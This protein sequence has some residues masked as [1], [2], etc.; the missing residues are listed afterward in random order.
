MGNIPTKIV[1]S[2][3]ISEKLAGESPIYRNPLSLDNLISSPDSDIY[4][5]Q[6]VLL[7]SFNEYPSNK[8]LG[9]IKTQQNNIEKKYIFKTYSEVH[10][11][12]QNLASG[13]HVLNLA[14]KIQ[15]N[16]YREMNVIG[17]WGKNS[18]EWI[19]LDCA[20][21]LYNYTSVCI[22]EKIRVEDL[23]QIFEQTQISTLFCGSKQ[24]NKI[25]KI[26][27]KNNIQQLV[28]LKNIVSFDEQSFF[29]NNFQI[30]FF[31]FDSVIKKGALFHNLQI[32]LVSPDQVLTINFTLNQQN[33]KYIGALISHRNIVSFLAVLVN[34]QYIKLNQNDVY[35][36]Y[37]PLSHIY[38][39]VGVYGCLFGGCAVGFYSG[40]IENLNE[41]LRILQPTILCSVPQIYNKL[42]E[43]IYMQYFEKAEGISKWI[44]EKAFEK[45]LQNFK[46]SG[47]ADV[48][49][50]FLD[51]MV[52]GE[53]QDS[54]GGKVRLAF[55][56]GAPVFPHVQERLQI[57]F[58][59]QF[60]QVYG[61][62]QSTG[63]AFMSNPLDS[64][65]G[66]VGGPTINIEFKIVDV[67]EMNYFTDDKDGAKGELYIRG[68]S[69]FDGYLNNDEQT[70]K[71]I[72]KNGWL[73]TGD[74]VHLR[75]NG[76]IKI[77]DNRKNIFKLSN[78]EYFCPE[79]LEKIYMQVP[80]ISDIYVHGDSF[81]KYLVGIVVLRKGQVKS[82]EEILQ[83]IQKL[84]KDKGLFQY[85]I[86]RKVHIEKIPFQTL[87][88][89]LPC[90]KL[91]R[92]QTKEKYKNIIYS[93]YEF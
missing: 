58:G 92:Y 83:D 14:Q 13:I 22:P 68:F 82:C 1:Y 16:G 51:K 86:L 9:S 74:I 12:C 45:K 5:M 48:Q 56:S 54:I 24:L 93:L 71:E 64:T 80:C 44:N 33:G 69:V 37:L 75:E 72:D 39:R 49:H 84:A 89:I 42:Y 27:Q 32:P 65:P 41:D 21:C 52:F 2:V 78:G 77:I 35:F 4:T 28:N 91:K 66:H 76:S 88:L 34:N 46:N 10:F 23:L 87:G 53:I 47:V 25:T 17:I 8:C 85:E 3:P 40:D 38:E 11:L 15:Q 57:M 26:M 60:I 67:S 43:T 31:T 59:F 30:N 6:D 20:C 73:H 81:Q 19:I 36:S 29:L 90:G 55:S 61:L 7:K 50:F 70:R 63:P 79:N 18:D 62:T